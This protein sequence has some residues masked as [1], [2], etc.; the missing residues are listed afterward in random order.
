MSD[1]GL[2]PDSFF[3]HIDFSSPSAVLE[4]VVVPL[5]LVSTCFISKF[6]I[7]DYHNY[8]HLRGND[9]V[10]SCGVIILHNFVAFVH[11]NETGYRNLVEV[12]Y[13]KLDMNSV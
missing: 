11:R 8:T 5:T 4:E 3:F 10:S 2:L 1:P 12:Q 9:L 6:V 13:M 7:T